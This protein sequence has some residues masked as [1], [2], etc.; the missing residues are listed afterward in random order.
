MICIDTDILAIYHIFKRDLRYQ[1]T[2]TF[3]RK[4]K[5]ALR[6]VAIFSLLEVCGIMATAKQSKEAMKLFDE[7]IASEDVR[8][9]YPP[10]ALNSTKEFWAHQNAELLKRI[11]RGIRLGDAAILWAAES[12]AC[13]V[14]I[15]WNTKHFVEKTA[16]K[17]QTPEEWLREHGGD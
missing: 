8:V 15:T 16:L 4:S 17:V 12:N 3:M 5:G 14:L 13:D 11:E 1:I 6:A 9:L 10:V 7:Y 2:R